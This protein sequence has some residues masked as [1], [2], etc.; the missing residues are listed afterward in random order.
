M[1]SLDLHAAPYRRKALPLA[2]S[3]LATMALATL[4]TALIDPRTLDGELVWLKPFK[5]AA[6]LA[7]LLAT[8]HWGA[9]RL[10]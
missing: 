5:F 2:A 10:P 7:L 3:F 4:V 6:S 8:L 9:S 1:T